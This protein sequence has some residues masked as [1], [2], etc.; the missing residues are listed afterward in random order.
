MPERAR[1]DRRDALL[2]NSQSSA[3]RLD[4]EDA[5]TFSAVRKLLVG[6][7]QA[8]LTD[9]RARMT[10]IEK[11]KTDRDTRRD[12]VAEVLGDALRQASLTDTD[13]IE[14]VLAP[15]IGEGIRHQIR[16]ERPAMVAAMV[17]MVGTLVTGAMGEAIGKLSA[18]INER[19]EK[20]LSLDGI[21]LAA[22]AKM[23]G[24]SMNAV[25][26]ADLRETEVRRLYL[27]ER[28]DQ[29]LVFCWPDADQGEDLSDAV[30]EE[31]QK[32]ALAYG[33][34]LLETGDHGL[35]SIAIRDRHLV[36]QASDTHIVVIE[37]GGALSDTRRGD[38]N[39]ACFE[40]LT[41]V[42]DLTGDLDDVPVDRDAMAL[43]AARIVRK[44]SPQGAAAGTRRVSPALCLVAVLGVAL[45]GYVGWRIYDGYR[46]E[47]RAAAVEDHITASFPAGSLMLSVT[48]DRAAG[49]IGVLGVALTPGDRAG[50]RAKA[51]ELAQ[52]YA[53]DFDLVSAA[54]D[55]AAPR[56]AA[57]ETS[58]GTLGEHARRTEDALQAVDLKA[59]QARARADSLWAASRQLAEWV[60]SHAIFFSAG[61]S[62]RSEEATGRDLDML[63]T[64]MTRAPERPLRIIGYS[65][66]IGSPR[67][68][69]AL[70]LGRAEQVAAELVARGIPADR[71]ILLGQPGAEKPI[72]P[73][74]GPNSPNRRVEFELGFV[75]ERF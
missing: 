74:S 43:F 52:P 68:N 45:A 27:F 1:I 53:L 56:L 75:G 33:S 31:I 8:G 58:L 61:T 63:A 71:L 47:A 42:S 22:R 60:P 69:S 26:M 16:T 55:S 35:R 17:P 20:L 67:D 72:S 40:V 24:R 41:F 21:R 70:S 11:T 36:L 14:S 73:E 23:T 65:D 50:I 57:I 64:L 25:L 66:T 46:I 3:E 59:T 54:P 44:G 12:Q 2:H 62:Y 10:A 48:G 4:G 30:A 19:F 28:H 15:T 18:G 51:A 5:E 13:K 37:V 39:D 29:K 38:L 49:A 9:L 7:E 6:E 32:A 34:G